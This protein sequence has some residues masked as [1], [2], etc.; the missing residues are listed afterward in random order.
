MTEKRSKK[1]LNS[2]MYFSILWG[3]KE[4]IIEPIITKL[5]DNNHEPEQK[6]L[7]KTHTKHR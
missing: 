2:I 5:K 1:Y 6:K 4:F 3:I 7:N